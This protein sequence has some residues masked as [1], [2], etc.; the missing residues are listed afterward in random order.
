MN[1]PLTRCPPRDRACQISPVESICHHSKINRTCP[2]ADIYMPPYPDATPQMQTIMKSFLVPLGPKSENCL[3][4]NVW[5]KPDP[6]RLKPVLF[7]IHGGR[8][9]YI[10]RH[11]WKAFNSCLVRIRDM[12]CPWSL[13]RRPD[14]SCRP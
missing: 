3:Y 2:G 12:R 13:L 1:Q 10:I 4:L 8:E 6:K 5:S 9:Q 7:W 14:T 11:I